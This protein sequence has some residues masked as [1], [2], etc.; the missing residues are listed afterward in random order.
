[1]LLVC[2][3][4]FCRTPS[5]LCASRDLD[6][7]FYRFSS[8][9]H[10]C[11]DQLICGSDCHSSG[12]RGTYFGPDDSQSD[13][14]DGRRVGAGEILCRD[15]RHC[16]CFVSY[17]GVS[18]SA[19]PVKAG[20]SYSIYSVPGDRRIPRRFGLAVSAGVD[21]RHDRSEPYLLAT[22]GVIRARDP[23]ALVTWSFVRRNP[24]LFISTVTA[25]FDPAVDA[26][27][28]HWIFLAATGGERKFC[29][30]GTPARVV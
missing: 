26:N 11:F 9:G 8:R 1:M 27:R 22:P 14:A 18:F 19:G 4:D 20:K 28:S 21:P 16:H 7:P 12:S 3:S 30:R 24:F 10:R 6:G 25:S 2:K 15:G 23:G 13:C 17:R 29:C 5:S